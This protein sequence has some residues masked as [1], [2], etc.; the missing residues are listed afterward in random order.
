MRR[1]G[2]FG[3]PDGGIDLTILRDGKNG[4]IQCKKWTHENVGVG[5][6]REL[7]GVMTGQKADFGIFITTSG[8]TEEAE[9]EFY[10]KPIELINH[11]RLWEMVQDARLEQ[12]VQD[13]A[14]VPRLVV[15]EKE[16]LLCPRCGNGLVLKEKHGW[17]LACKSYATTGCNVTI[18]LEDGRRKR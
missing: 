3:K 2:V 17:F 10:D 1:K 7:H 8:F 14:A 11:G 9:K 15:K 13:Y 16:P 18:P 12:T 5:L 4:V 6:L